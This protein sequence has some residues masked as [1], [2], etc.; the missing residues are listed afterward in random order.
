MCC[1]DG[2]S[3]CNECLKRNALEAGIPLS[4]IEGKT[5]LRDH[6]PQEYIDWKC[7]RESTE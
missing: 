5:K 3:M 2:E 6:F 4:V 1:D 7:G